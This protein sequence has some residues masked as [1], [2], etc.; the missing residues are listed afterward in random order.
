MKRILFAALLLG[1]SAPAFAQ[2][3]SEMSPAPY[4]EI[5]VGLDIVPDVSTQTYSIT[6][7]TN[8]ATGKV[9][10]NYDTGFAAGAE[11]GYAGLGIPQLRFGIG[12]DYLEG[13]FRS[14]QVVGTVNGTSGSFSFT[15]ADVASL[16]ASLDNDVNLVSGNV[17]YSLPMVGPIRPYIGAGA[18]VAFVANAGSNFAA[19]ATAGFR[20]A[21]TDNS[22]FGVRY[23]YYWVNSPTDDAG[24]HYEDVTAHSVMAI[25]GM[26]LD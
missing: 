12:Y 2:D 24:I 4:A 25:L 11:L 13:T 21:L 18:G 9:N 8:T 1:T 7:G 19:S 16:G 6:S 26:Y 14:G 5:G 20:M 22:Y 23:R 15:R 10:L 3:G 17:Y